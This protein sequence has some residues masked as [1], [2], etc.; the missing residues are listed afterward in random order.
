METPI[1][2]QSP[3]KNRAEDSE[4]E[5]DLVNKEQIDPLNDTRNSNGK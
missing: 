3:M 5:E 1:T 4:M 2:L